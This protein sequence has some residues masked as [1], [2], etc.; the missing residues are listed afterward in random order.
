MDTEPDDDTIRIS[1]PI[2]RFGAVLKR[3]DAR[4]RPYILV[5]IPDRLSSSS[6]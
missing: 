1:I 5:Q 2:P 4:G 6:Y 3:V